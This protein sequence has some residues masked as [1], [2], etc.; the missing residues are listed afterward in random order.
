LI[1]N[2]LQQNNQIQSP[3][4][5]VIAGP[6]GSGKTEI[7]I[8][9]ARKH[10][11]EVICADARTIYRKLDIGTAKPEGSEVEGGRMVEGIPH[12]LLNIAD[13]SEDFSLVAFG[14]CARE[15]LAAIRKRGKLPI[16]VGG[17]GLYIR[18]L[19]YAY[20]PSAVPPDQVW[21]ELAQGLNLEVLQQRLL[22]LVGEVPEKFDFHNPHRLIRAIEVAWATGKLPS[23]QAEAEKI[24]N[25]VCFLGIE[26]PRPVLY[27]R[28]DRRVEQMIAAGWLDEVGSLVQQYGPEAPALT[29]IGYEHLVD[30]LQ[31]EFDLPTAIERIQQDT[32]H[33]AKRQLTWLRR[34]K[35]LQW[36]KPEE[37][38]SVVAA[39][40]G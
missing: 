25:N 5:V 12:H 15:V 40:L 22:E 39:F 11:G 14:R 3:P 32:R 26:L 1:L 2:A 23:Q 21:R 24:E 37:I 31:G 13:P 28:I 8:R 30:H 17:T 18:S 27:G 6:T 20:Q 36:V 7:G 4:L 9:L 35:D 33:Y 10:Q 38:D 29:S 16:I 34:E 19:L